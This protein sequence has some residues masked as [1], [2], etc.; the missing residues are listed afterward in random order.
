M[1]KRGVKIQVTTQIMILLIGI[2]S[3]SYIINASFIVSGSEVTILSKRAVS[4]GGETIYYATTSASSKEIQI[5]R[6]QFN[7]FQPT[8]TKVDSSTLPNL[9][10]V[11]KDDAPPA[12]P[13]AKPNEEP[14]E[15]GDKSKADIGGM[16]TTVLPAA[17][18]PGTKVLGGGAGG[19]TTIPFGGSY[20]FPGTLN[21][22]LATSAK[23]LADGNWQLLNQQGT[24]IGTATKEQLAGS[25]LNPDLFHGGINFNGGPTIDA[26]KGL[27]TLDGKSLVGTQT[28]D[29]KYIYN[30]EDK[31]VYAQAQNGDWVKAG[32]NTKGTTYLSQ[33]FGATRGGFWD[34]A[35]SGLEWAAIAYGLG[36]MIGGMVGWDSS[37]TQA[38]STAMAAGTYTYKFIETSEAAKAAFAK[39][40]GGSLGA[41][42]IVGLIVFAIM[43]KE[44]SHEEVSFTCKP[45]QAPVGGADCEKCNDGAG[46]SEYRCRSLG[47][48]CQLLNVG[49]TE[50]RCA[51]VNPKDVKSPGISPWEEVLTKGYKY[52]DV[53]IRP[54]GEGGEPGRMRIVREGATDGCVEAFTPLEFGIVTTGPDGED[55]PAQCKVDY[56]HTLKFDDMSYYFGESNMFRYNHTQKLALPSPAAINA[57]APELKHDGTYS[58]YVRCR[59]ANGNENVDEFVISFCVDKSEDTTPPKI[60]GTS[61]GNEMPVKFNQSTVD[62]EVYVNEPAECKWSRDDKGYNLMEN[63]MK[64]NNRVWEMNNNMVYTCKTNL[65]GIKDRKENVFYFRCKDNPSLNESSR[66]TMQ[67]SYAYTLIGTEP[68]NIIDVRPNGTTVRGS[69]SVVSVNVEVETA[70]GYKNGEAICYY[71]DKESENGWIEFFDTLKSKHTQRLDLNEGSYKYYI[72]CVDLGGN[73]DDSYIEFTVDVDADSPVIVRVYEENQLLKIITDENSTCKYSTESCNFLFEDGIDMPYANETSHVAEWKTE[74]TYYIRCSDNYG[75]IP[76][77]NTCSMVVRP[78]DVIE[79]KVREG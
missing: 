55:E 39:F 79:Q 25:G 2:I 47:Q 76:V 23:P 19:A 9:G 50:E 44:E 11:T 18:G 73:R 36:T 78:Y 56:N 46:C 67:E 61:I 70:N 32:T 49:S 54:P 24:P 59:D 71:N 38:L 37:Q 48:A 45:W 7:D 21:N 42:L 16:A 22:D 3:F 75:N 29:G 26:A 57:A 68:L 27:K 63:D 28:A 12:D 69:T 31:T 43:Y 52:A 15:Q 33:A 6:D 35:L 30:L 8:I 14:A 74:N 20:R 60:E 17:L 4:S 1:N 65:T 41:G 40:P 62:L 72:K 5:T 34:A 53:R 51:W 64:C 66:N 77:S 13:I 10:L 58:L